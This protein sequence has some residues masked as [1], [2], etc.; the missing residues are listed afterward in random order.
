MNILDDVN[1]GASS[2]G[3]GADGVFQVSDF[4]YAA[5]GGGVDFHNI[6]RKAGFD[7][8][9]GNTFVAR[10]AFSVKFFVEPAFFAI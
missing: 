3:S 6:K 7:F 9:A 10:F 2:S 4:V 5:I 1:F 8:F